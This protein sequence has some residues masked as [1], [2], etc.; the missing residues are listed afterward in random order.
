MS[1]F[2]FLRHGHSAAN[3]E[4]LL[5]GQLPGI[6]LS[7]TGRKQAELLIDRIGKGKVDFVHVSPIERCQLTINPWLH[8]ANS[9]SISSLEIKD[10]FS[11][12]NFGAWSG[13]KLSTL[14][15][16]PLWKSV[17]ETPSQVTFPGGESFRKAQRR[18]V[19]SFEEIRQIRGDKVHLIVS[20][21]DTIKLAVA[22]LLG[23]KL[24]NFQKLEISPAS[25][26]IFSGDQKRLSM[27]TIN[28][29]GTLKEILG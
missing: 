1:T 23:M 13:K 25:F 21:S 14:R 12:I 5:T 28:N 26:T 10:G 24:D 6:G 18:A 8:S 29:S 7:P 16:N 17:Q 27:I 4:G 3:R 2:I 19:E 22:H 9:K 20:H 15:R 11:E